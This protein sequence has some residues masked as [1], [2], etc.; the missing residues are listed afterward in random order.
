MTSDFAVKVQSKAEYHLRILKA[1]DRWC[2]I[3]YR[4][5]CN[6]K[7]GIDCRFF[8]YSYL[9]EAGVELPWGEV[10]KYYAPNWT[11]GYG[12]PDPYIAWFTENGIQIPLEKV[13]VG[14]IYLFSMMSRRYVTHSGIA[15]D[16]VR[17]IHCPQPR[18]GIDRIVEKRWNKRL[19]AIYR[20]NAIERLPNEEVRKNV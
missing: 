9:K 1:V 16:N 4:F 6:A 14:D 20:L 5:H 10:S 8:L 7:G 12:G 15:L 18:V 2:G 19:K 13:E 17:F 11:E 3:P